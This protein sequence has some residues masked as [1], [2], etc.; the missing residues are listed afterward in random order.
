MAGK[1]NK[2]FLLFPSFSV[3]RKRQHESPLFSNCPFFFSIEGIAAPPL[4]AWERERSSSFLF[5]SKLTSSVQLSLALIGS[6]PPQLIGKVALPFLPHVKWHISSSSPN[7][8]LFV[9]IPTIFPSLQYLSLF[10][11]LFGE[12]C[13]YVFFLPAISGELS[14]E[15]RKVFFAF[16]LPFSRG[17][18]F[19]ARCRPLPEEWCRIFFRCTR[20]PFPP[21]LLF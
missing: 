14:L 10:P 17:E 1:K 20:R 9:R 5:F 21:L 19:L 18:D 2:G 15:N 12:L 11:S 4:P 13:L 8:L 16:S 7:S 3:S 6:E